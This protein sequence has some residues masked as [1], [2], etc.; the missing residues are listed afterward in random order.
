VPIKKEEVSKPPLTARSLKID[1]QQVPS[2]LNSKKAR[3]LVKGHTGKELTRQMI[4]PEIAA[5]V[6]KEYL[7]PMFEG[8][9]LPKTGK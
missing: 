6:V 9:I 7:L 2:L 4:S 8:Q 3:A 1:K 5:F